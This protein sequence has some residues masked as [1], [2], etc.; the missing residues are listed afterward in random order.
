MRINIVIGAV[1]AGHGHCVLIVAAVV[2]ILIFQ[3]TNGESFLF[4]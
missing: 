1:G 3:T 4:S 2:F